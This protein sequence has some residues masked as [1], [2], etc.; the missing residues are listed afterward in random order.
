MKIHL[1]NKYIA[2]VAVPLI[3]LLLV[4]TGVLYASTYQYF[5]KL[6]SQ[7]VCEKEIDV[8]RQKNN[9]FIYLT[10]NIKSLISTI[11]MNSAVMA[12]CYEENLDLHTELDAEKQLDGVRLSS[13]M[14]Q[15]I[16]LFNQ[17]GDKVYVAMDQ[18]DRMYYRTSFFDG[19]IYSYLDEINNYGTYTPNARRITLP[20]GKTA[21]VLTFIVYDYFK[22]TEHIDGVV[23]INVPVSWL[24]KKM[25]VDGSISDTGKKVML[26]NDD[27]IV[28]FSSRSGEFLE[29]KSGQPHVSRVMAENKNAGYFEEEIDG[30]KYLVSYLKKGYSNWTFIGMSSYSEVLEQLRPIQIFTAGVSAS[31]FLAGLALVIILSRRIAGS[32]KKM[33]A[34]V[35]SLKD[36]NRKFALARRDEFIS[37]LLK[38]GVQNAGGMEEEY[39]RYELATRPAEAYFLVVFEVDRFHAFCKS[40][41]LDERNEKMRRL[42]V[43]VQEHFGKDYPCDAGVVSE[44]QIVALCNIAGFSEIDQIVEKVTAGVKGLQSAVTEELTISVSASVSEVG[45]TCREL[46]YLFEEAVNN[47]QY[48]YLLGHRAVIF[49]FMVPA[50]KAEIPLKELKQEEENLVSALAR[51]KARETGELLRRYFEKLSALPPYEIRMFI[52][53]LLMQVKNKVVDGNILLELDE[54]NM[55]SLMS[56]ITDVETL[57]EIYQII[58]AFFVEITEQLSQQRQRKYQSMVE[59]IKAHIEENYMQ[60]NLSINSIADLE[61]LSVAYLGRI[62]KEVQ[63]C[64]IADYIMQVRLNHAVDLLTNSDTSVNAIAGQVGFVNSSYFYYVFKKSYEMTPN[65][66]RLQLKREE[67]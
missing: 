65:Q 57:D 21:D 19:T 31:V 30:E 51:M 23:A 38:E 39:H 11:R 67:C 66:Y 54:W 29:D 12:L 17:R 62:F 61:K 32:L 55:Q 14:I 33:E 53:N 25:D 36:E 49:P 18:G 27:G 64:S 7:A 50:K 28:T 26:I 60:E 34:Q 44:S 13:D 42:L 45:D 20:N 10:E 4:M 56:D 8:L 2:R 46:P 47:L 48:R 41:N 59:D 24:I 40:S 3:I 35:K 1:N 37:S 15:S 9:T 63:G 58:N 22:Q 6:Y 43:L 16:Y 5:I 52:L